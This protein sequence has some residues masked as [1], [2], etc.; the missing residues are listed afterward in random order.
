[1]TPF[2]DALESSICT[3]TV[4]SSALSPV[5]LTANANYS[6]IEMK[7]VI[8]GNNY[9]PQNDYISLLNTS[10]RHRLLLK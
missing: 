9:T 8:T 6:N 2:D 4:K 3:T 1:M 7:S 5:H 10:D